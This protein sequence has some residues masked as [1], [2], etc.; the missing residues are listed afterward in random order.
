VFEGRVFERGNVRFDGD[1][2]IFAAARQYSW[3]G[4]PK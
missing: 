3:I 4:R 2:K 1:Y